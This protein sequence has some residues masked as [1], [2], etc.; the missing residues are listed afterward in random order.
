MPR[1]L[2]IEDK[3]EWQE[4]YRRGLPSV[5]EIVGATNLKDA[6][7]AIAQLATGIATFDAIVVDACLRGD[8]PDTLHLVERLR[9][10]GFTGP[11]IAGSNSEYYNSVLM[12]AGCTHEA[13]SRNP[14]ALDPRA[15]E[16]VLPILLTVLNL[17][18]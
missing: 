12:H 5:V 4:K 2:I 9:A 1:V 15:K 14:Q 8:D 17:S 3:E 16:G 13:K 6:N 10:I 11:I 7:V 18:T